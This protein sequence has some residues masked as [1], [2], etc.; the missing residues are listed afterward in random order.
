[1]RKVIIGREK[2]LQL[3]SFLILGTG[4]AGMVLVPRFTTANAPKNCMA[5]MMDQVSDSMTIGIGFALTDWL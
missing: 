4:T 3:L 2:L 1:M 5:D